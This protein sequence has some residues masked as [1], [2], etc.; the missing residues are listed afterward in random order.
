MLPNSQSL[1]KTRKTTSH[2]EGAWS[3]GREDLL[4]G[5]DAV[6]KRER[7]LLGEELLDVGAADVRGLLDLNDLEDLCI[8]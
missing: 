8:E 6:R 3:L 2:L 7:E 1:P 5:G 4:A